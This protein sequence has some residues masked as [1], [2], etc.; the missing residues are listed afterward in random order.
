VPKI[1]RLAVL[2]VPLVLVACAQPHETVEVVQTG[3]TGRAEVCAARAA[4]LAGF[5]VAEVD[6]Q[7]VAATKT[8]DTIYNVAVGDAAYTC[9]VAPDYTITQFAPA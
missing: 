7:Q 1:A 9:A 6:V 3:P 5:T 8:G 4:E 2:A